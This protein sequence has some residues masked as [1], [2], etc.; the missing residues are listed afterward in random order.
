[1]LRSIRFE[2]RGALGLSY[3]S[4]VRAVGIILSPPAPSL[5]IPDRPA[6]LVIFGNVVI[7]PVARVH[8]RGAILAS[9]EP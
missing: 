8:K 4:P 3:L 6:Y 2:T 9:I 1:M 5:R 7:A